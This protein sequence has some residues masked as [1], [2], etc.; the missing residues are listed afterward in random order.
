MDAPQRDNGKKKRKANQKEKMEALNTDI[1]NLLLLPGDGQLAAKVCLVCD[2]FLVPSDTKQMKWKTFQDY[3]QFFATDATDAL[4]TE[5]REHYKCTDPHSATRT[6]HLKDCLL[7]PRSHFL[8][9]KSDRKKENPKVLLCVTCAAALKPSRKDDFKLPQFAIA[10]GMAIGVAPQVLSRLN[11][12]E[13]ALLSQARFRGHLFTYWGGCHRSIKGW[14]SFYDVDVGHTA[15]VLRDVKRLTESDNIAIILCG[16]FT[17][18]Q[19]ARVMRKVR[20]NIPWVLEAFKWLQNH[21]RLYANMPTPEIGQPKIIDTSTEVE[22]E[23]TDIETKEELSVVF[24]DGTIRT[25]GCKDGA[26]FDLM[27]AEVKAQAPPGS[28]PILTSRPSSRVI[29]DYAGDNMLRA[30]PLQFPYGF[31]EGSDKAKRDPKQLYRHLLSLSTP[32]FHES[33][34]VLTVHNM[35]EKQRAL[36]GKHL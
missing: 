34:F 15:A 11:E 8:Y 4:P 3:L 5:L 33:C 26:E 27:V 9:A 20:I 7:S 16:P 19:R 13:I 10:N 1:D 30:F 32:A 28:Q 2:K 6:D 36:Q 18:E 14:H 31:G 21:N 29:K 23:N 12:I 22:S 35:Y 25:G 17:S 24:P